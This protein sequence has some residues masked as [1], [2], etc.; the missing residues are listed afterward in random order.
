MAPLIQSLTSLLRRSPSPDTLASL[1]SL[2]KR[3]A[4]SPIAIQD[5]HR[6]AEETN[7]DYKPGI[8]AKPPTAFNKDLFII[9]FA[10]IFTSLVLLA[11]YFFFV[12]KNG[13]FV[14]NGKKD[15]DDYKTTVLRR[16]GPDGKTLSNAT[17]STKLGGGSIVPKWD[18]PYSDVSSA[19]SH[20]PEMGQVRRE[21]RARQHFHDNH[22]D[23]VFHDYAHEKPAAVGG[24]N[25]PDDGSRYAPT[26]SAVSDVS[27]PKKLSKKDQK[28]L[29]KQEKEAKKAAKKAAK[30]RAA[31]KPAPPVVAPSTIQSAS[32]SAPTD[33][34]HS[35]YRPGNPTLR[36]VSGSADAPY[37][38]ASRGANRS[39]HSVSTADD[40]TGTK[41]YPCHIPGVSKSGPPAP[42]VHAPA[43]TPVYV[44]R[45]SLNIPQPGPPPSMTGSAA[46]AAAATASMFRGRDEVRPEESVSQVGA[47]QARRGYG[48][49]FRRNRGGGAF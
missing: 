42:P 39:S 43:P 19:K 4:M 14:W 45:Q 1:A 21:T 30:E 16:K 48:G 24:Y 37:N 15:W 38:R 26:N 28:I 40:S 18:E 33:N 12:A 3:T 25:K 47:Q 46:A 32:D 8:G 2:A 7:G 6:R 49:G 22:E 29:D 34:Y 44:P 31:S 41:A 5:L 23:P 20:D 9:L 35:Q 10:L 13:G 27:A 17:K 11:I 36:A